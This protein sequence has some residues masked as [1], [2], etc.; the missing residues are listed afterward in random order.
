MGTKN[1]GSLASDHGRAK[2]KSGGEPK[3][4]QTRG[5]RK[6]KAAGKATMKPEDRGHNRRAAG[7]PARKL[8]S[9]KSAEQA[10]EAR[11][12]KGKGQMNEGGP[13]WSGDPKIG[14]G[15]TGKDAKRLQ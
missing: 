14:P 1:R 5:G 9:K 10:E 12:P 7:T 2:A 15:P 13:A 8:P 4:N 11:G 3:N 6:S